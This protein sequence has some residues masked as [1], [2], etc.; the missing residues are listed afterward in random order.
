MDYRVPNPWGGVAGPR[1]QRFIRLVKTMFARDGSSGAGS[2]ARGEGWE[3]GI[4]MFSIAITF[5]PP[6]A[7]RAGG[8][9]S[10]VYK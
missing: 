3:R 9:Y 5:K 4:L 7:Q 2:E 1:A 10:F 8:I 6:V